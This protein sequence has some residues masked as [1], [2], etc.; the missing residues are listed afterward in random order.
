MDENRMRERITRAVEQRCAPLKPD[1]FMAGRVM[2]M[3][4]EKGEIRV[5]KKLSV[6]LALC[7]LM[8]LLSLTALAAALLSGM[9]IIEFQAIPIAM[10]NDEGLR[11]N[12]I[13]SHEELLE[14]LRVAEENGVTV[15][16]NWSIMEALARGEGYYE[17]ETIMALCRAAF[18]GLI[19]EWTVDER[20]WFEQK[21]VEIGFRDQVYAR[22][23]G[24]GEIPAEEARALAVSLLEEK[25][26][27]LALGDPERFRAVEDFDEGGWY[28]TFHPRTLEDMKY[29]VH[30]SHDRKIVECNCEKVFRTPYSERQL[31]DAIDSV[32][33]Y[34]TY[35]K[36]SWDLAG[37][38]AFGEM[39]PEARHTSEWSPEYDGYLATTYL[40]PA[41]GDIPEESARAIA[42]AAAGRDYPV[43]TQYPIRSH[44]LLLGKG[45]ARIWK[46]TLQLLHENGKVQPISWEI[47]AATGAILACRVLGDS[48]P[49][50][51]PYML[52]ETLDAV[53][54][55]AM[56]AANARIRAIEALHSAYGEA[57]PPLEDESL[58]EN[59]IL[60]QAGG[61][62][63]G[64]FFF[65]KVP[66]YGNAY[67]TVNADGTTKI[68]YAHFEP[69]SADNLFSRMGNVYGSFFDWEQSAWVDF[70]R[71]L[72]AMDAPTTF[73]GRLFAATVYPEESAAA[74]SLD[75]AYEIVLRDL[76]SRATDLGSHVLISGESGPVWKLRLGT[77]PVN[78]L[79]EVD[80]MT[81][82]IL[83][84][85][86]FVC[87][88]PDFDHDMKM[89]TLRS[90][91]MP[92]A[93]M[94]FGP[95]RIA[96]ELTV[97]SDF[98]AFSYDETVFMNKSCYE[99]TVEGMTVTFKS[100]DEFRPSY[101]TTIL[102]NGMDAVIEVFDIPEPRPESEGS[103]Y[104][105]G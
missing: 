28:L 67:V 40:L 70:S 91:Y 42:L 93:L 54:A 75:A 72:A 59:K 102:D 8:A 103:P 64:V 2:R 82:E 88:N 101:R 3:A 55:G 43:N 97:K 89:F 27:P 47:D 60:T 84:R 71:R 73:E 104:G 68:N 65:S 38:H 80:A 33:G 48:A 100:I 74:I 86:I 85:E 23:P 96:M 39:L 44:V 1:P 10:Q 87:Q 76:D 31:S 49:V 92:A 16:G 57:V 56:T 62:A 11:V 12:D 63:F 45:D 7:I 13:Y 14:I 94:E 26:G 81:G 90:T 41:E 95:V 25:Y 46:V 51:A 50:F 24:E 35:S 22:L 29:S 98:D 15:E 69:L 30:F 21:L 19:Y 78:T 61:K 52:F 18:G 20:Y 5:K 66:D 77:S 17:E 53:S 58:Y 99:V 4:E 6:G 79:Y 105:N 36:Q 37:W 32:Y 83:D 9:E 34:R